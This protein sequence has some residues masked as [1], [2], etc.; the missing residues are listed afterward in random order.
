LNA[1]NNVINLIRIINDFK[2]TLVLL[3]V[4]L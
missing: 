2:H 3:M 1:E 4:K